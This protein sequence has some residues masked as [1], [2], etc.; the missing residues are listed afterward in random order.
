MRRIHTGRLFW[1]GIVYRLTVV[2]LQTLFFWILTGQLR[3]ALGTSV[4]WNIINMT[5]YYIYHYLFARLF[6]LGKPA[7]SQS[8]QL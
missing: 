4:S 6:K 8:S 3:L 2:L 5:Y 7:E 1:S